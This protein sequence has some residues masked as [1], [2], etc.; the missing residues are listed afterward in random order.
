MT[1]LF[2][3]R[4]IRLD[5]IS[6][7]PPDSCNTHQTEPKK[8]YRGGQWNGGRRGVGLAECHAGDNAIDLSASKRNRRTT[9]LV[10]EFD[11]PSS[12]LIVESVWIVVGEYEICVEKETAE[13]AIVELNGT[14][15]L[16]GIGQCECQGWCSQVN[17]KR[18]G[19]W[20]ICNIGKA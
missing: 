1:L 9:D 12:A 11:V 16:N 4:D 13:V 17:G 15:I 6:K 14:R 7:L 3:W 18:C 5:S 2:D 10:E 20:N 19:G 8:V